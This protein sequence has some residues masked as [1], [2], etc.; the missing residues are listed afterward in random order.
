MWLKKTWVYNTEG[1]LNLNTRQKNTNLKWV[2]ISQQEIPREAI[3]IINYK[4]KWSTLLS[5]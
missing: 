3:W 4:K 5:H 2:E 1:I